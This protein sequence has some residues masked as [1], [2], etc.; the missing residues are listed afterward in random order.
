MKTR[1]TIF[2]LLTMLIVTSFA[3][4]NFLV[5]TADQ[6]AITSDGI[7]VNL[8]G[9]L[10][11]LESLNVSNNGYLVAIPK[12]ML[13][14]CPNCRRNTYTKGRTCSVCGFPDDAKKTLIA[15]AP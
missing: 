2:F 8:N 15:N 7:M 10:F 12:P 11:E 6:V 5:V 14:I 9:S 1:V 4:A 3:Y 13:D